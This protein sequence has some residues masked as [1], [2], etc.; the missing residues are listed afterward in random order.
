[1]K[2]KVKKK[3]Y[4]NKMI[5]VYEINLNSLKMLPLVSVY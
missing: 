2:I 3:F 1:M 5:W 4:H